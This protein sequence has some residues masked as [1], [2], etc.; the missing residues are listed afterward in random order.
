MIKVHYV[1]SKAGPRPDEAAYLKCLGRAWSLR[2][3]GPGHRVCQRPIA[4]ITRLSS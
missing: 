2:R 3:P 1:D 4:A